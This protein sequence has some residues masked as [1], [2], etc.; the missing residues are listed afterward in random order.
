LIGGGVAALTNTWWLGIIGTVTSRYFSDSG[1][2]KAMT[3][4]Q[5]EAV[6]AK[7]GQIINGIRLKE[8]DNFYS[9]LLKKD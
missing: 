6:H 5:M 7:N 9:D 4:K 8:L 3:I 2:K 1:M